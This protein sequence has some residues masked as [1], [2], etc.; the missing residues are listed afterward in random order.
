MTR[1]CRGECRHTRHSSGVEGRDLLERLLGELDAV[2]RHLLVC[3]LRD[4][5]SKTE[6][7]LETGWSR[8]MIHRR[9]RSIRLAARRL[10]HLPRAAWRRGRWRHSILTA[11]LRLPDHRKRLSTENEGLFM[12]AVAS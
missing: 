12:Y 4:G 8:Q 6:I 10:D 1:S 2:E 3:I 9:L 7:A 5:M 11:Y